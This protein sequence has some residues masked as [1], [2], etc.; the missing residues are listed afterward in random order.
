MRVRGRTRLRLTVPAQHQLEIAR[1]TLLMPDA[2]VGVMGG[3][4]K[5]EA[6]AFLRSI[7]WSDKRIQNWEE[8]DE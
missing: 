1:R 5:D 4:T 6:R 7:G 8:N 2:M 3:P